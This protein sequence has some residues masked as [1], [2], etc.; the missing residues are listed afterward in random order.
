MTKTLRAYFQERSQFYAVILFLFL[1][2]IVYASGGNAAIANAFLWIAVL[3][4]LAKISSL[5]ERWKQPAVLGELIMGVLLGNLALVGLGVFDP[6][7][8]DPII[9]F[10]A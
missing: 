5:I 6:V 3:L 9:L 1:P 4:L 2:S 8:H 10:L 7:K